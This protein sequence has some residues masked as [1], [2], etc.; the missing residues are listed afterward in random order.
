LRYITENQVREVTF[1]RRASVLQID[2]EP[3]PFYVGGQLSEGPEIIRGDVMAFGNLTV[4]LGHPLAADDGVNVDQGR[5]LSFS[6]VP[7]GAVVSQV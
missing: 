2:L 7:W 5:G 6:M 3:Q 4:R 1:R